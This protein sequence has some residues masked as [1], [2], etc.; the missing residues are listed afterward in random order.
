MRATSTDAIFWNP[1]N[2]N[3]DDSFMEMPFANSSI[4]ISN[5]AFSIDTYNSING[6]FITDAIKEKVLKNVDGSL[7]INTTFSTTEF[8]WTDGNTGLAMRTNVAATGRFSEKY[9]RLVLFGNSESF[10]E[11]KRENN[12]LDMLS[13]I[14]F[15]WSYGGLD[16]PYLNDYIPAKWGVSLSPLV[17][18]NNIETKDYSGH[19]SSGITDEGITGADFEQ[20]VVLLSSMGGLGFKG[21]L[22]LRTEPVPNL[23][24]G[25]SLDNLFG[26]IWWNVDVQELHYRIYADSLYAFDLEN[27]LYTEEHT[28]K[29][30]SSRTTSLPF[31]LATGAMYEYYKTSL[32][33]D[34][35][36]AFK[37]TAF[38]SDKPLISFGFETMWAAMPIQLGLRLGNA[39]D[40]TIFSWGLGY[41][42]EDLEF[43]FNV[44]SYNS[45]LPDN[46]SNGLAL[47]FHWRSRI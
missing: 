46:S 2:L 12:Q 38:T 13:Y 25:L 22:G 20:D 35:K 16:V 28:S 1:A 39:V 32:S 27:D 31:T 29:T 11:F 44:Q 23:T 37:N 15:T 5:N 34:Y 14:D 30:K 18:I 47:G 42:I 45:V 3:A 33:V 19:F 43:G 41:R 36:Q 6:K 21:L 26:N 24:W 7:K 40:P 10:Y 9:L 17:G 4:E 8:A